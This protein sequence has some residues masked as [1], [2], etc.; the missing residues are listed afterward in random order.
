MIR[1]VGY[2]YERP[3]DEEQPPG[4]LETL[5][6]VRGVL[7]VVLLPLA[8]IVVAMVDIAL[9]VALFLVHPALTPLTIVPTALAI[10]AYAR[11]ERRHFRP[12]GV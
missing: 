7:G 6:I 3:P 9:T 1:G 2:Y 5:L 12:P 11:W 10:W 8:V 4:C